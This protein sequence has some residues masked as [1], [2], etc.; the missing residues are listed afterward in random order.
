M[1]FTWCGQSCGST[2]RLFLHESLHDRVLARIVELTAELHRPGPPTDTRTTMGALVSRQQMERTLAYIASATAE[3]ATVAHGGRR[4]D[5]A[6]LRRGYFVEPTILAGVTPSMR[7]AREEIFGPVLAVFKWT[8]EDA[9]FDVVNGVEYG[10]TAS[11]WTR[12]LGT[13][14]RAAARVQAGYIWINGSSSHFIGAPFGGYKHSGI[15]REECKEE[16][17]EFTQIKNV[18][19]TLD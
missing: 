18:N 1:N 19:V 12:G 16:L 10:L 4:C 3:G 5:D 2:S 9:L 13:A 17:L 7:V 8:D 11:I 15:G 14:H 6:A